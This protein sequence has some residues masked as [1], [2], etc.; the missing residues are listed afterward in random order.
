MACF[1]IAA[2]A[3]YEM[4][5]ERGV[6]GPEGSRD[7]EGRVEYCPLALPHLAAGGLLLL[8]PPF[9]TD[10]FPFPPL[11]PSS[12]PGGSAP[13]APSQIYTAAGVPCV[14]YHSH[15]LL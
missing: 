14:L 4:G 2:A 13:A 12:A 10:P 8:P 7:S 15:P 5:S 1:F 11:R 9:S 3:V 6:T